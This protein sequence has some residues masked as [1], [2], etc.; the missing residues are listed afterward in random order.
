MKLGRAAPANMC[1][2]TALQVHPT[3]WP[4]T[5]LSIFLSLYF[6]HTL[7]SLYYCPQSPIKVAPSTPN[8]APLQSMATTFIPCLCTLFLSLPFPPTLRLGRTQRSQ[9]GLN[10][11]ISRIENND[12]NN[13]DRGKTETAANSG[14]LYNL[15]SNKNEKI[16]IC[17]AA[18]LLTHTHP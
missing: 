6:F 11:R 1:C 5:L 7:R 15:A 3:L 16:I 10:C 8:T 18:P 12:S 13:R 2:V 9:F 4:S 17:G 14:R